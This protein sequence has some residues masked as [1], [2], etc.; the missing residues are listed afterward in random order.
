MPRVCCGLAHAARTTTPKR[1]RPSMRSEME[2]RA[3]VATGAATRPLIRPRN[4]ALNLATTHR[5]RALR[6]PAAEMQMLAWIQAR[7]GL[8]DLVVPV[9]PVG[10]RMSRRARADLVV[11][12]DLV[13]LRMRRARAELVVP[14]D[15]VVPANLVIPVDPVVPA[16]L[17]IPACPAVPAVP[18]DPWEWVRKVRGERAMEG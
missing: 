2:G 10:L 12:V 14:V 1:A 13:G 8:G 15:L 16:N 17:V 9:N 11:P 4:P 5:G 3:D 6:W 18:V 7:A